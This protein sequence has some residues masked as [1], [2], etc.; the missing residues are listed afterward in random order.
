VAREAIYN[1]NIKWIEAHKD[2]VSFEIGENQ[3]TDLTLEEF[4]AQLT[5]QSGSAPAGVAYLGEHVSSG[6]EAPADIDWSTKG[7][8]SPVKNQ[9][10]CGSCW[11][12]STVGSLEGRAQISTGELVQFSEQQ[13][14]DCDTAGADKGC[15]GGLMDNAFKYYMG[16]A[17][18]CTED[19]YGYKGVAGSCQ[20]GSCKVGLK[21]SQ[22]TGF[23]D[24][25]A[26][27]AAAMQDAVA[28]GPV[29][30]A[31]QANSPFFQAYKSGVFDSNYCGAT[32]D[33]GVLTVGYGVD[34]GKHYWKVKNSWGEVFGEKGYIRLG[35]DIGKA[36]GE[37]GILKQPSY[38]VVSSSDVSV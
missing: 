28:E 9:G 5:L 24:V 35:K 16:S 22:I 6:A 29:S 14:V 17:G 3:F 26:N 21:T 13:L 2:E 4:A 25:P 18:V 36:V 7:A 31:I 34:N 11:A 10:Q 30:V 15:S 37:C 19:S 27:N 33:H 38:P 23:K 1:S 20:I 8:V 12:F 32:L